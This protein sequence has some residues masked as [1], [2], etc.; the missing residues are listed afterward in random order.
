MRDA[1][2]RGGWSGAVAMSPDG[3]IILDRAPSLDGLYLAVGCSGTNFKT[4]PAIGLAL[5][6][7]ITAGRPRTVD[8]RPFRATRFAE[9]QHIIGAHEYG[10]ANAANVWR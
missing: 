9:G 8:L 4:A 2:M 1:P 7:W 10:A 6:E 5:T 3:H